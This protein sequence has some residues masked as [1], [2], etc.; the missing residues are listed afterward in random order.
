MFESIAIGLGIGL[1]GIGIL[2]ILLGGVR[3]IAN[4]KVEFKKAAIM[5]VPVAVFVISFFAFGTAVQAV[6]ATAMLL[7]GLMVV[8]IVITGTRGT[9]KF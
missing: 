2:G 5:L 9:F 1:V 6:V 8:S 7:A 3:S 4:G